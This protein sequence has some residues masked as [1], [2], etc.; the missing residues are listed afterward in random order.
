MPVIHPAKEQLIA[1]GQGKLATDE[2]LSVEQ[3]LE[4]CH[5][6]CETLLDLKDDTFIGLVRAAKPDN[7]VVDPGSL[8]TDPGTNTSGVSDESAHSATMLVQSGEAVSVD[9]LPAELQDH[10]RY[11]IVELIGKG[12]MGNVYRAEHRLMNR[13]VALKLINSQLIRQPQAVERF[14]RE[15]QAA[16]KLTHPNIVT[17]Y[18]AEQAGDVHFLV[19][20]FV[21]GTDLASVVKHR[22]PMS[23][24]EACECIRQVAEGLQH[25]HEKGMVHR[26]IKPHNMMLSAEG[27]VRILDFGLAGFVTET[28]IEGCLIRPNVG[29]THIASKSGGTCDTSPSGDGGYEVTAAHL[30][31]AGSVMGTPDYIAPEQAKDAH[32]ADIRADIYSLGCTLHFLL[33]GKPPFASD[34]LIAKLKAHA[35]LMPES[36]SKLRSDVPQELSNVVARMMAKKPAERFQ[37]PAAVAEALAPFAKP[38]ALPP[39]RRV[40]TL[41]AALC[42]SVAALLA[43]VIFVQTSKGRVE[44]VSDVD[45]VEVVIKQGGEQIDFLDTTTGSQVKWLPSGEYEIELIGNRNDIEIKGG[46]FKLSRWGK[47]IVTLN[48]KPDSNDLATAW[49]AGRLKVASLWKFDAKE[50]TIT[51]DGVTAGDGEWKIDATENRT[52]RLFEVPNPG[53]EECVV[54]Y[55][56]KLKTENVKGR[57]FLEMWVRTPGGESFSKGFQNAVTGT[58]GWSE[59]EIPFILQKGQ[60]SD[61]VKLNVTIEGTGTVWIKDMELAKASAEAQSTDKPVWN[62][63]AKDAPPPAIAPFDTEQAKQHQEAWAKHL[64]VPVEYTNSIGMTFRLIPPGEFMMGSTPEEINDGLKAAGEDPD[65][66][67][68]VRSEAPQHKVILTQPFFLGAH[69]VTQE[70]YQNVMGLNPSEFAPTGARKESVVGLDTNRFPVDTVSWFD[71]ADF[72]VKLSQQENLKSPYRRNDQ[73]VVQ[74]EGDG[75]WLPT[76]AQREFACRAGTTTRFW[77]G[78]NESELPQVAWLSNRNGYRSNTVGALRANPLGLFDVHGNNWE[79]TQDEWSPTYY[80]QVQGKPAI[81]PLGPQTAEGQRVIRGGVWHL[82]ATT[83]R[84]A[85]RYAYAPTHRWGAIGIRVALPVDAVRQ[86]IQKPAVKNVAQGWKGWPKDAPP[87]AIAPFAAEQAKKH[88]EAWARHLGVPVEY[89]NSIGMKFRLI[90]P[91]EFEMGSTPEQI[92]RLLDEGRRWNA[93][94]WYLQE[95]AQEHLHRVRITRPFYLGMHEATQEQY[96]KVMQTNPSAFAATGTQRERVKGDTLQYPVEMLSWDLAQTFCRRLGALPAANLEA[97]AYRLPT[98]AEWEYACRAGTTTINYAG[99]LDADL[100]EFE[101]LP[102][103][104]LTIEMLPEAKFALPWNDGYAYTAPV[105]KFRPNPFGLFDMLG[106]VGEWCREFRSFGYYLESPTNDPPG[107][108]SGDWRIRRSGTYRSREYIRSAFRP[109]SN[110]SFHDCDWGVRVVLSVDAVRKSLEKHGKTAQDDSALASLKD[111]AAVLMYLNDP[112]NNRGGSVPAA[113]LGRE[114]R[115][116]LRFGNWLVVF[117]GVAC[118]PKAGI[119]GFSNLNI[120]QRGSS[121]EGTV[122]FGAGDKLPGVLIKFK[123]DGEQNE[124]SINNNRFKLR[125]KATRLEFD[126]RS[127]DSTNALQTIFVARDGSTRLEPAP[128]IKPAPSAQTGVNLINDPSFEK[129]PQKQLPPGWSPWFNEGPKS[130]WEIVDGGHTGKRSLKVIAEGTRAVVFANSVPLDR[131]KRY[132]IKGWTKFEGPKDSRAIIKFNYFHAGKWLGVHDLVGVTADQPGWHLLEKT[133]AAEAYPE[134]TLLVPTCHVEGSGTAWF[135]DLELIAFDRD[136]LSANFEATHGKNNRLIAPLDFDRWVGEW[137]ATFEVK[138]NAQSAQDR[139]TRGTLTTRKVLDD[140]FLLTHSAN[141]SDPTQWLWLLTHDANFAAYRIWIF[142]SGGEAFERRGQWDAASQMLTLQ[143]IP[144]SPGVT[145]QSTDRFIGNDQIESTLLVKSAEGQ[146]TRDNRWS[147]KKKSPQPKTL[148]DIPGVAAPT[149]LPEELSLLNKHAGEWTIRAKYK[150]SVW[151]PQPREETI[152]EKSVWILGGRF[153]MTRAFNEKGE[154]TSIWLATYEPKEKSSHAWFFNADGSSGQWRITWDESSRGFH[155]RAID[156]P[157]G[158]I[159]TSFNRWVDDNTFDNQALIK[160]ENGRVLLDGTQD[161]RRMR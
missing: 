54:L 20:E 52:V 95:T 74:V 27:Q 100:R 122:D 152:I 64:G 90:P 71:A 42:M 82:D 102:D 98:E 47:A 65:W 12:G 137:D 146:V 127:Y 126:D 125:G 21:E 28:A 160:D 76:E 68:Y 29:D 117:E 19:M 4:V 34:S 79:W 120:P 53:V 111:A 141:E 118:D 35:E 5:E 136:K 130:R 51:Q 153:L 66:Q 8:Q 1:F 109:A 2:S 44:I 123:L 107:P 99:D 33:T 133:D 93:Y 37:T 62:G 139:T 92:K 131:S 154:L 30:T 135:D 147:A 97:D 124:L 144:P 91:G 161:K 142:G 22:G 145:G 38:T 36:L 56:A 138:P 81:D 155:W 128:P 13:P 106:N 26:D 24:I 61:L 3:H 158:W 101:N 140:R 60:R 159:G 112:K 70:Q 77:V 15:V 72:C 50:P 78:N 105:G 150:P 86:A 156:M 89:T 40:R 14:R 104:S 46:N 57:A 73:T 16:A 149:P 75:Y 39:R 55:R 108:D 83:C 23:V 114:G 9:D 134:A 10:P 6:C 59:Y 25:A 49:M 143:L 18:D 157:A 121:G 43:G 96:F 63:W 41:V 88:Q 32:S 87:P 11:R 58:T 116:S 17:A 129:T 31:M 85:Y 45:G 110:P 151:N 7:I 80:E 119:L 84:S 69:E 103:E 48:R 132:A 67:R 94:D 115:V 148:P 113:L